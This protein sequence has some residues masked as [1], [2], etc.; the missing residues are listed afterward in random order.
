[1][2]TSPYVVVGGV[3]V[4]QTPINIFQSQNKEARIRKRDRNLRASIVRKMAENSF[5]C[6]EGELQGGLV[7]FMIK[8]MEHQYCVNFAARIHANHG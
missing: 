7:L 2:H 5:R 6:V 4:G 8:M 1:M 3:A